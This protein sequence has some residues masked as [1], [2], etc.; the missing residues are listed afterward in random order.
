MRKLYYVILVGIILSHLAACD[1]YEVDTPN[2]GID[3]Q[4]ITGRVVDG[5]NNPVKNVRIKMAYLE[6]APLYSFTRL[7]AEVLTDNDGIFKLDIFRKADE[8]KDSIS[9]F[10]NWY[11]I[12]ADVDEN[13]YF[14][15]YTVINSPDEIWDK[16]NLV[17]GDFVL[18]EKQS[19]VVTASVA[20]D[21]AKEIVTVICEFE[22]RAGGFMSIDHLRVLPDT[23]IV[24]K[25]Q[26]LKFMV[27]W[28]TGQQRTISIK[29]GE[30]PKHI[31]MSYIP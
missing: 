18:W 15:C 13:K 19:V 3:Q 25:K 10:K 30:I 1:K 23:L 5:D 12:Y 11:E 27:R 16:R 20:P 7:K 9:G 17:L 4:T 8:K 6:R 2:G 26:N 29:K 14:S 28:N 21:G 31:D 24:Q 22:K